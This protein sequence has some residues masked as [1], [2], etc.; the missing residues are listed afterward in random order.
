[1]TV[2]VEEGTPPTIIESE[3]GSVAVTGP[4]NDL[5]AQDEGVQGPAGP[6]GADGPPG[7]PATQT[8]WAQ[9]INAAGYSLSNVGSIT[10]AVTTGTSP[11]QITSTTRVDNLN[12]DRVDNLH[13]A[14][15]GNA[16]P[17]LAAA[18]QWS[19]QQYYTLVT[20]TLSAGTFTWDWGATPTQRMAQITGSGGATIACPVPSGLQPGTAI[21]VVNQSA[22]GGEKLT[23]ASSTFKQGASL[24]G[25]V[26]NPSKWIVYTFIS[27]GTIIT[28]EAADYG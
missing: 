14:Q 12:V 10:S 28:V 17:S 7:D 27:N 4:D 20:L 5:V 21:L 26:G 18:N 2:R 8:P 11:M 23:F 25:L 13:V 6:A 9:N 16:I 3:D 15:S 22:T 24:S 19:G 1:M